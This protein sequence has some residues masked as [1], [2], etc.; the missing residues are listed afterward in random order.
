MRSTP[1]DI[2]IEALVTYIIF[3]ITDDMEGTNRR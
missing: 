3:I 2:C 1:P